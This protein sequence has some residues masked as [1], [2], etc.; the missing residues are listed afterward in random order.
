VY[1][2]EFA[3]PDWDSNIP[4]TKSAENIPSPY[5]RNMQTMFQ[6]TKNNLED[7]FFNAS[8][9][10]LSWFTKGGIFGTISFNPNQIRFLSSTIKENRGLIY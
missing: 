10:R 4:S 1:L 2:K 8:D 5:Y 9:S 3:D 7:M 6:F